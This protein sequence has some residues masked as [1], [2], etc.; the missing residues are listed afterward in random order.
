M[1]L[2]LPKRVRL[3]DVDAYGYCLSVDN[4]LLCIYIHLSS[5]RDSVGYL[6]IKSCT[7]LVLVVFAQMYSFQSQ[8]NIY[9]F[10]N[11][12][13]FWTEMKIWQYVKKYCV[14]VTTP[15]VFTFS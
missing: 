6:H 14:S 5:G 1:M 11:N 15:T 10:S 9:S 12:I 13:S 7:S 4:V 3:R 2:T 8:L